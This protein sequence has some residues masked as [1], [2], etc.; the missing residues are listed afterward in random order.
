MSKAK[1]TRN[2]NTWSEAKYWGSIRSALRKHF[3]YWKPIQAAKKLAR[4]RVT[5]WGKTRF[6]YVC[7]FC[8][9]TFKDKHCVVDHKIPVGSLSQLSDLADFV[10]NLTAEDP[11]AYQVLCHECHQTKTNLEKKERTL[12]RSGQQSLF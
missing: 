8:G 3:Q 10:A 5:G 7:S 2:S 11:R 4:V 6:G 9:N 12:K 1:K